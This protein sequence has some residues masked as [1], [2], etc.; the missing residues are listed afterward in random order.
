MKINILFDTQSIGVQLFWSLYQ[1]MK[2]APEIEIVKTGFFVTNKDAFKIFLHKYPEFE[3]ES[4]SVLSEWDIIKDAKSL[5]KLDMKFLGE[6]EKRIADPTLWNAIISDRRLNYP[7]S[8]QFFQNYSPAYNHEFMLK[9]VQVAIVRIN[10][11]FDEVE[12]DAILGLNA[13]TLYDYLYYLIAKARGIPYLQL[14]LTRI[15]NYVS[16]FSEPLDISPH[17]GERINNYMKN[18][19]E[20]KGKG[21][22]CQEAVDF[23]TEARSDSLTYE[24]AISKRKHAKGKGKSPD[25]G[26]TNMVKKSVLKRLTQII[27]SPHEDSHYP[28]P[29]QSFF[30]VRIIKLFRKKIFDRNVKKTFNSN[31]K[32]ISEKYSYA[33]YPLNTEPEVALLVYGRSYRNQIETVRNVASSL[34]VGWK[35]FVKE[36][37]NAKGYRSQGFYKKLRA[38]PN[39]VLIAPEVSSDQLV[40]NSEMV[41]VVF[42][43]IG[44]EAVLK[45]KPVISLCKTPYGSF[46]ENMVR[47]VDSIPNLAVEIRDLFENYNYD[48]WALVCYVAAH[49]ES[50]IP[51]NLFTGLLGKGGRESISMDQTLDEQYKLLARYSIKR[52]YEEQLLLKS[53]NI[54][55]NKSLPC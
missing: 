41:F 19:E 20:L 42:G 9:L 6:W 31:W 29:Q 50:S 32:S 43:T 34:P 8:A 13:V 21:K 22:L 38:I 14:K 33:L 27:F 45:E 28:T 7:V 49:I 3:S 48:E 47:C 15:S 44:L 37:P 17:I 18:P 24:G 55:E 54:M 40:Q 35:L 26:A 1:A 10:K 46:P 30:Y 36:H 25:I 11:H 52:I 5:D 51:L 23:I 39:V 4:T 12:P 53:N 16:Y 2:N